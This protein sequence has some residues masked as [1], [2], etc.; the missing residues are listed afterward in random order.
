MLGVFPN[1]ND[2]VAW[3]RV[4]EFLLFPHAWVRTAACRFLGL[5]FDSVPV[6]LP[7]TNLPADS[8]WSISGMQE[9]AK[10][11]TQQLKSEHLDEALSMQVIKKSF[12]HR[13]V[14]LSRTD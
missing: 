9:V 12:P 2:K 7:L 8:P 11:L 14:F 6:A 10:K 13:K 4:T 5:L 3:N 1:Q